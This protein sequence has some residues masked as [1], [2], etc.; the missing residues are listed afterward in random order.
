M[1]FVVIKMKKT[2][3]KSGFTIVELLVVM[4][5]MAV[6][7]VIT[8]GTF[9]ESQKKARDVK[10]KADLT[11]IS[12]ALNMY[13]SDYGKYP[14]GGTGEPNVANLV[15]NGGEFSQGNDI[16]MKE[17]PSEKTS[18][19]KSYTYYSSTSGKSF[20]LW[21]NLENDKD[22]DC[23]TGSVDG[24]TKSTVSGCIYAVYSSNVSVGGTLL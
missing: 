3:L 16:Y 5:I 7:T 24:Y 15:K 14:N 20:R 13:Y 9:T 21:A 18:G 12:K 22:K 2:K 4:S 23:L 17:I 10:R 19:V 11:S 1:Q 8:I 6:L